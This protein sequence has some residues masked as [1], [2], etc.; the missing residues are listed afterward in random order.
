MRFKEDSYYY[1]FAASG[2]AISILLGFLKSWPYSLLIFGVSS[3]LMIKRNGLGNAGG[4]RIAVET[5]MFM[6]NLISNYLP[7]KSIIGIMQQSLDKEWQI[8]RVFQSAIN[9]YALSGNAR[10][11]FECMKLFDSYELKKLVGILVIGL[12]TG[13]DIW[14]PLVELDKLSEQ[15]K[16]KSA[17]GMA[18]MKNTSSLIKI[19]TVL[20][21]PVFAGISV[22]ILGISQG[23]GA[24]YG[25]GLPISIV[26]GTYLIMINYIQSKQGRY[27]IHA[28]KIANA[29]F[30][31]AG[32]ML[33]MKITS[34]FAI[35]IF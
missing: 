22:S 1:A 27:D 18:Y 30:A 20:F 12:D 9:S 21:L 2:F 24:D 26:L 34:V 14:M 17:V 3:I 35:A 13:A 28:K 10:R 19:G 6:K 31:S 7:K 11:S 5:S 15:T 23:A 4:R 32:A 25:I 8:G 16:D 29:S 33:I